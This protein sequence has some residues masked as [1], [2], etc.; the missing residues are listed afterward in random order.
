MR[1]IV[2]IG[3]G[4][5]ARACLDVVRATG[6]YEVLGVLEKSAVES[7][8]SSIGIPVIGGDAKMEL[9][10]ERGT[11]FLVAVGQTR[12]PFVRKSLFS[13]L[14]AISADLPVI[15]APSA[16][17]SPSG[18]IGIGTIVMHM[19]VIGPGAQVG[20]NCII[21]TRALIEHDAQ[22]GP[23]CH[24]ATGAVVNG[25]CIVGEGSFIGSG[26]AL[27]QGITVGRDAL[28]GMGAVV[29]HDVADGEVVA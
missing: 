7:R 15:T 9:L 2:L 17:V 5:H 22:V 1:E 18:I 25:G 28:I 26:A 24:V 16:V 6:K 29:R 14:A 3:G 20:Y 12:S 10:H 23:H 27:K 4:G 8:A 21:N 11:S 13:Q 19:A